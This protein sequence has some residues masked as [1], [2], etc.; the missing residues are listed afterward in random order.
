MLTSAILDVARMLFPSAS[1]PRIWRCLS[2]TFDE[3]F[4][5]APTLCVTQANEAGK[6][7]HVWSLEEIAMLANG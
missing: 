2:L 6:A 1:M 4:F 3:P 5:G 7:D